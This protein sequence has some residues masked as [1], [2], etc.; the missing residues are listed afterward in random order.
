MGK[1]IRLKKGY[2]IKLIGEASK[3]IKSIPVSEI[4]AIKPTDY[5]NMTP[6]M[7]VKVEAQGN[8]CANVQP[9]FITP[10]VLTLRVLN[11]AHRQPQAKPTR[12]L[13]NFLFNFR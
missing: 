3:E 11:I 2:D 5:L 13:S 12:G 8:V 6:K 9:T 10:S 1:S 7:V 4:F